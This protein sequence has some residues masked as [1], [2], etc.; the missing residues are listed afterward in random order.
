M[1]SQGYVRF[2]AIHQDR[3]VFVSEDDLWLLSSEGGRAERLTAGVGE[4]SYPRFSPDGTQL[5]FVGYEEGPGEVYVMPADGDIAQRLTFQSASCRVL[6]WSPDGAEILYASNAG[7]FAERFEVIYAISPKGGQPRQLPVGMAN[8]ISYGPHGGVVIGRNINVREMSHQKRYRGGRV[9]HLW[10]DMT[11]SGTFQRLLHLDGN[12]ADPCWVG[13]RIYFISDHEGVGNVYSCTPTGEDLRRHTDH[14]DFYARHLSSDGQRLVYHAGA[15][16]YLFDP[17][18]DST[19]HLD[20]ELPSIRTQRNRKFVPA[21]RY[22]DSYALHPQGYAVALTTRGKAFSMGNWEGPVLQHGELDGVRYRFLEWLN[23]GKRLVAVNDATGRESLV[24]FH[25]EDASEP[26]T[27]ADI[28]F[29]RVV[30]M[31]TL[32]HR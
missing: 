27:F 14:Q 3:I 17:A 30:Q 28:E 13:E 32:A 19:H 4:V 10:C 7:Q 23:D 15:D 2:P 9:G 18:S 24:V 11:G 8:A 20:V 21:G 26:K 1:P 25:P 6:G 31:A 5:A 22:L 12:I 16:L 29:G